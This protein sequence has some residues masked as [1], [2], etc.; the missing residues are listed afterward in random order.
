MVKGYDP[1]KS[2]YVKSVWDKIISPLRDYDR[3]IPIPFAEK[4]IQGWF[5]HPKYDSIFQSFSQKGVQPP[6]V[7][8]KR[9]CEYPKYGKRL[10]KLTPCIWVP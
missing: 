5:S 1:E 9:D 4:W 6:K 2:D 3:V 8:L 7:E 10:H